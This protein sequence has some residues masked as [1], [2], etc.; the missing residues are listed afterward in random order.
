MQADVL[1]T[2]QGVSDTDLMTLRGNGVLASIRA[3]R[4][5][6]LGYVTATTRPQGPAFPAGRVLRVTT[7]IDPASRTY[8]T[9][10]APRDGG[11]AIFSLGRQSWVDA[12][13][14]TASEVCFQTAPGAPGLLLF[15]D[16]LRVVKG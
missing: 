6:T 10:V 5:G 4:L 7:V 15:V 9:T 13:Q 12:R 3:T 14:P 11:S 1:V 8:Q 16:S 2:G